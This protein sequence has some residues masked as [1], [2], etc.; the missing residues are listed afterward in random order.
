MTAAA[1]NYFRPR[2]PREAPPSVG[3]GRAT[4]ARLAPLLDKRV[5]VLTALGVLAPVLLDAELALVRGERPLAHRR[6]HRALRLAE[7]FGTVRP[8]LR[9][10]DQARLA[11]PGR[12]DDG[13]RGT[14]TAPGLVERGTKLSH[15]PIAPDH[16]RAADRSDLDVPHNPHRSSSAHHARSSVPDNHTNPGTTR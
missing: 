16:P 10:C 6:L 1:I 11:D 15:F 5:P 9:A 14:P 3:E 4:R 12:T 8:L 13:H 7:R 2:Q